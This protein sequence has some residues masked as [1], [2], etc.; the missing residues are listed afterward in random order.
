MTNQDDWL[1]YIDHAVE[2]GGFADVRSTVEIGDNGLILIRIE[3]DNTVAIG[4][5]DMV[6]H[7]IEEATRSNTSLIS[8]FAS[9]GLLN[10]AEV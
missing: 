1:R 10:R 6:F 7:A 3:Y 9:R 4:P 2:D 5:A 8:V